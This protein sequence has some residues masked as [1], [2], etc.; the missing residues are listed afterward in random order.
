M[1]TDPVKAAAAIA[2]AFGL[3][4]N[5]VAR[6]AFDWIANDHSSF[7]KVTVELYVTEDQAKTMATVLNQYELVEK[8]EL[9]E[10]DLR[11]ALKVQRASNVFESSEYVETLQK[12]VEDV[13]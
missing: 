7:G 6:I 3:N 2:A 10:R 11:V 1:A 9:A 8:T 4:A 5:N 12:V 13:V